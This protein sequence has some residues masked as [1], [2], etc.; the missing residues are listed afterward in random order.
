MS[1]RS[2]EQEIEEVRLA[3]GANDGEPLIDAIHRHTFA[4]QLG[5][6]LKLE[7]RAQEL[8]S[9]GD[10]LAIEHGVSPGD[11]VVGVAS[12]YAAATYLRKGVPSMYGD[13]AKPDAIERWRAEQLDAL[14]AGI[15]EHVFPKF[16]HEALGDIPSQPA[17]DRLRELLEEYQPARDS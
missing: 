8:E 10:G 2:P 15:L 9:A 4:V 1:Q 6:A 16:W 17:K 5:C 7:R 11:A 12:L 13:A 3:I 14:K